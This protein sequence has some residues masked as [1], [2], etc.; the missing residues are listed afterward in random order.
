MKHSAPLGCCQGEGRGGGRQVGQLDL[1][2][3]IP[4][5]GVPISK[6]AVG[7]VGRAGAAFAGVWRGWLAES[8]VARVVDVELAVGLE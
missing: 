2:R 1:G 4:F 6:V 8:T 5:Y 3:D 7:S